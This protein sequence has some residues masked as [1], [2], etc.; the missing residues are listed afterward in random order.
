[1]AL[2]GSAGEGVVQRHFR[3]ARSEIEGGAG[4]EAVEAAVQQIARAAAV[5]KGNAVADAVLQLIKK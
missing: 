5:L 1:M 2:L 4:I 3:H